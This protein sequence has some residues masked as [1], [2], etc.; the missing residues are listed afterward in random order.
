MGSYVGQTEAAWRGRP[1]RK[2]EGARD[3]HAA[4]SEC[5]SKFRWQVHLEGRGPACRGLGAVPAPC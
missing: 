4:A 5:S 3:C 1:P 2:T